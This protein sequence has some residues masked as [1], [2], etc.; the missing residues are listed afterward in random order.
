MKAWSCSGTMAG[1]GA[2]FGSMTSATGRLPRRENIIPPRLTQIRIA[3]FGGNGRRDNKET[4]RI[5]DQDNGAAL[6]RTADRPEV[7]LHLARIGENAVRPADRG[8]LDLSL[9]RAIVLID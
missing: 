7:H 1:G 3:R 9:G 4:H 6:S 2:S 8:V 5:L